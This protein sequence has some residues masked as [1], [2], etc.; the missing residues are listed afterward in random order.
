[1]PDICDLILDDHETLRRRFAELDRSRDDPTDLLTTEWSPV[2]ELLELH[3]AAEEK[4]FYPCL[5]E[6]GTQ[7]EEETDDAINDH[8]EIRDAV[9]RA[10]SADPGTG[11]WWDAVTQAREKNSDHMAEEERGAIADLRANADDDTRR[12]L[13]AR[14]LDYREEHAGLRG[15]KVENKDPERYIEHPA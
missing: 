6:T 7:A 4:V 8:N 2:G 1:M 5:L 15:V 3:A 10:D 14:W 13:G 9:R 11:E 12:D